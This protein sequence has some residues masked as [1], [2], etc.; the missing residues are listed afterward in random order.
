M[1]R[2]GHSGGRPFLGFFCFLRYAGLERDPF[3]LPAQRRAPKD[4]LFLLPA[5]RRARKRP[6]FCFLHNAGPRKTPFF[7][8]CTTQGPEKDP[9]FA[10]CAT[11]GPKKTLFLLPAQ[12]RARKR[13]FFASCTTQ[14]PKKTPFLLPAQ[15]RARKRPSFCFLRNAGSKKGLISRGGKA[16]HETGDWLCDSRRRFRATPYPRDSAPSVHSHFHA[17]F[18]RS[19]G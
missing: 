15:R 19:F 14:G 12:R 8:S 9:L 4:T 10:S 17:Y 18:C 1:Q 7:A 5:Q 13:P 16:L 3:L 2:G 11:Q 6:S